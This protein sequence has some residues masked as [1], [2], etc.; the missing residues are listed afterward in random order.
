MVGQNCQSA[1]GLA[2]LCGIAETDYTADERK[3]RHL[4]SALTVCGHSLHRLRKSSDSCP[5][6]SLRPPMT[7]E[8]M[9]VRP[10]TAYLLDN[11]AADVFD[12]PLAPAAAEQFLRDERHHLV[13]AAVD[14][15]VVGFASGVHYLHPDKPSPELWVNEVGVAPPWQGRGVGK[16][17]LAELLR[18]G[19]A[20]GC[21]EA[22]VLT[23]RDNAVAMRLYSGSGGK[24]IAP[25]PVMFTFGLVA[26][27]DGAG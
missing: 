16:A 7:L 19:R 4:P 13:V 9:P 3:A 14:G 25:D 21:R 5:W 26:G 24:E 20:L 27:E 8:I 1:E 12:D 15:L 17:L 18:I 6:K 23:E 11:I 22:W 2:V 10:E